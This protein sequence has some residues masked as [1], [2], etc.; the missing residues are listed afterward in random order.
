VKTQSD[1]L[2]GMI[3]EKKRKGRRSSRKEFGGKRPEK[4][5]A[6]RARTKKELGQRT[7]TENKGG[8]RNEDELYRDSQIILRG[9]SPLNIGKEN[10]P[11]E[12]RIAGRLRYK[13]YNI[14][15]NRAYEL[16]AKTLG[17]GLD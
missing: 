8:G 17:S 12:T 16:K 14:F 6:R 2:G 7:I 15:K 11:K 13:I 1:Y 9:I 10:R 4:T 5:T 3:I